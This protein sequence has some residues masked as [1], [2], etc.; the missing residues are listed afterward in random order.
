[1]MKV[2]TSN[3]IN[4]CPSPLVNCTYKAQ[5]LNNNKYFKD[6]HAE[7]NLTMDSTCTVKTCHGQP[8]T[9]SMSKTGRLFTMRINERI[10]ELFRVPSPTSNIA[11]R[12]LPNKVVGP[13]IKTRRANLSN[14]CSEVNNKEYKRWKGIPVTEGINVR[15]KIDQLNYNSTIYFYPTMPLK[16][17]V[18][19][20]KP[21]LIP[22]PSYRSLLTSNADCTP[23]VDNQ[24]KLVPSFENR[25]RSIGALMVRLRPKGTGVFPLPAGYWNFFNTVTVVAKYLVGKISSIFQF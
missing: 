9:K 21:A 4:T 7:I 12:Q 22:D 3:P 8:F 11:K 15:Q 2:R 6:Q 1:M 25:Q 17:N 23:L 13:D 5:L 20:K 16:Y 19:S 18:T 10:S 14:K 24:K